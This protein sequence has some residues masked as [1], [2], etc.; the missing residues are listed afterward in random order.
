MRWSSARDLFERASVERLVA[1]LEVAVQMA[2]CCGPVG[3]ADVWALPMMPAQERERVL[4][5]STTLRLPFPADMCVHDLVRA[6]VARTPAAVALEWE[7]AQM[8]YAELGS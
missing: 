3:D 7:G 1:R 5:A 4:V 6:Q 2:G 8:T